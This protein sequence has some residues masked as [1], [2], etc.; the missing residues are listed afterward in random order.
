M[1]RG[2]RFEPRDIRRWL[3]ALGAS[4]VQVR[5]GI[6]YGFLLVWLP[7]ARSI[8]DEAARSAAADAA[9]WVASS[10]AAWDWRV[11][12]VRCLS[13]FLLAMVVPS[14]ALWAGK[15]VRLRPRSLAMGAAACWAT[16]LISAAAGIALH[17]PPLI[18]LGSCVVCGAGLGLGYGASARV[19]SG[20]LPDRHGTVTSLALLGLGSG[21]A[22][23]S[24]LG[25]QVLRAFAGATRA[26]IAI[27]LLSMAAI[28]FVTLLVGTLRDRLPPE[29]WRPA[30]W[31]SPLRM[32]APTTV[33]D[34]HVH[35]R[36][37][38]RFTRFG[39]LWLVVCQAVSGAIGLLGVAGPVRWS[40][41][42]GQLHGVAVH[43][44][45][46]VRAQRDAPIRLRADAERRGRD[47]ST[48]A[49]VACPP[50]SQGRQ[51]DE[52]ALSSWRL[53]AL[54]WIATGVPMAWAID[55]AA[56]GTPAHVWIARA[57]CG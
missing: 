21:A 34:G 42:A 39:W 54:T 49:N 6:G 10:D 48:L 4:A 12:C 33:A 2:R 35:V 51:P 23:G 7:V 22:I 19:M 18:W 30:G 44:V 9:V 38:W 53:L 8:G 31:A 1:P 29:G 27:T 13:S 47:L 3:F 25:V 40:P 41:L 36:R 5:L 45:A 46:F 52:V 17:R 57:R 28:D 43:Y 37:F 32:T 11:A 24:S 14:A 15:A 20:W 55:R 16:G 50:P 26:E 56:S